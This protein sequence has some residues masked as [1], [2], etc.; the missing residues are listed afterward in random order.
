MRK[1]FLE[2]SRTLPAQFAA[3]PPPANY[4]SQLPQ[5]KAPV[6]VAKGQQSRAFFTLLAETTHR[7]IPNSRLIVIPNARHMAPMQNASAFNAA[8]LGH[9]DGR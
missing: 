8:I 2:N 9:L 4:C 6:T 1:V 3:P 5:L 7:C